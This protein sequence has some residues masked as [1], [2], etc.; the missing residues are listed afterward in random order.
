MLARKLPVALLRVVVR[1]I[2][3]PL[4]HLSDRFCLPES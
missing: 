2:G 4:E 1:V 3:K